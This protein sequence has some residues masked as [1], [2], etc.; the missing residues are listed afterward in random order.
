MTDPITLR[1]TARTLFDAG[2]AAADPGHAVRQSLM[3]DPV[4]ATRIVA[5]GKAALAMLAAA[6]EFLPDV[7]AVVVTNAEN[8]AAAPRGETVHVAG[9][10][11]PDAAGERAALAVEAFVARAGEGETVLVL[12]SG[13]GSAMLPAPVEGVALGDKIAVTDL[14]LAS[15]APID[16]I[17]TVRRALSRLKGGGLARAIHPARTVAML[18]SD[19]PRDEI[20]VIASGPTVPGSPADRQA[21]EAVDVLRRWC[22]MDRVPPAVRTVLEQRRHGAV[23]RLPELF[24][25]NR[26][27]GGN[28]TSVRAMAERAVQSGLAASIVST[29]L[30]GDVADAAATMHRAAMT[31]L[32]SDSPD[33][34]LAGGETTVV[35]RGTGTGGRNQEMALRF[36][37]LCERE[38][39]PRPWAFL[40]GG[41]DGRDGPTEAAGGLV[42][43]GT[44]PRLR[45]RGLDVEGMLVD[46]DSGTALR[47]AGDLLVTGPTGTN[48][49]DL[50]VLTMGRT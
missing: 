31:A 19:V 12:V 3:G 44:I 20:A 21:G 9:H 4:R 45:G 41:T 30:D 46:N 40:S 42:D 36:A 2:V 10:P 8:A 17:N 15:G 37:L 35:L 5:V 14:L 43:A 6:R 1:C 27:V 22:A 29:W 38:P 26:L 49:A 34:L 33:V 24:V 48:V 47:E 7:P 13:G 32:G 50:Q 28:G 16:A 11:V 39:P 25:E 18:L 23:E